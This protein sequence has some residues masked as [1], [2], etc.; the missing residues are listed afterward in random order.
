M[1]LKEKIIH[2]YYDDSKHSVYQSMPEFVQKE[3]GIAIEINQE[4]RGD[5]E[6]YNYITSHFDFNGKS[7]LDIGAN[8]GYFS[9]NLAKHFGKQVIVYEPNRNHCEIVETIAKHFAV[10]NIIVFQKGVGI[11]DLPDIEKSDIVLHLNVLHHAG[12][13]FDTNDV[14]N[15]PELKHYIANYLAI[16]KDKTHHLIFQMGYNW[17][18][19]KKTP[20]FDRINGYELIHFFIETCS[21][22]NWEVKKIGLAMKENQKISY[23]NMQAPFDFEMINQI[24]SK[25]T[26]LSEFYKRPIFICRS[27]RSD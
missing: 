21:Q 25:Q 16:L 1:N 13:D 11:E 23:K 19:N 6:R 12:V 20:I 5:V 10:N 27:F 17:G 24:I 9:L 18:G 15:I 3:L 22:N 26:E 4:W 8:S 7:I 14:R 2:W